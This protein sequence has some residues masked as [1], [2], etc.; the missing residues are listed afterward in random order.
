[1]SV[2]NVALLLWANVRHST[3]TEIPINSCKP[4]ATMH[5]E[6]SCMEAVLTAHVHQGVQI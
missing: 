4:N 3:S 5:S 1:M 2:R 6:Q